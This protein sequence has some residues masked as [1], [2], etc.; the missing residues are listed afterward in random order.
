MSF[1]LKRI[2]RN[3]EAAQSASPDEDSA[4]FAKKWVGDLEDTLYRF[5]GDREF[6]SQLLL[7]ASDFFDQ[8]M[9]DKQKHDCFFFLLGLKNRKK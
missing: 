1:R 9:S 3:W 7:S 8:K 5:Q 2:W 6:I 4:I